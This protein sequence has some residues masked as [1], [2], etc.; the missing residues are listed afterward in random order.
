[1]AE[2]KMTREEFQGWVK[3]KSDEDLLGDAKGQEDTLLDGLFDAM[4]EAFDPTAASG[5][6]AVIQYDI[7][8][9][10]GVKSYQL[11]VENDT[12][13]VMKEGSEKA[14]VTLGMN[15]PDFLRMM[16]LELD[17]MQAYMTGKLKIGGDIMFSQ[18]LS[19]WFKQKEN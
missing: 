19:R 15:L 13:T 18:N 16:A 9:P 1:M 3:G 8:A 6:T 4:K 10:D 7:S 2:E 11:K 17:G 5:Q 14:R 12:C